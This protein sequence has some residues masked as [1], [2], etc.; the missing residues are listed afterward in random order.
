MNNEPTSAANAASPAEQQEWQRRAAEALAQPAGDTDAL[1]RAEGDLLAALLDDGQLTPGGLRSAHRLFAQ[2]RA[3]AVERAA[4]AVLRRS[5]A[6]RDRQ[7]SI[8]TH[9]LRTP[10][11]SILLN[12]QM[13]ERTARQRGALDAETVARMLAVPA[14]QLRR[15]THMVDLLLDSARVENERLVLHPQPVDLCELVHDCAGRLEHLAREAG[16]A[17]SLEACNPVVGHW[18]RLRLEQVVGNLLTNAI[19]YGG[20]RVEVA[21]RG[22]EEAALIVRDHGDGIAAPDQQ[23]IFEPFERLPSA[24]VEDGAGLGLYIVREIVRAHGGRIEVHSTPGQGA[25]FSVFL[26]LTPQ[27]Q[28]I[29]SEA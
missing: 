25:T 17:V 28:P 27:E 29:G 8:A 23:R 16:C 13:L 18:D 7:L 5:L 4:D 15:L 3:E 2:A 14:R 10:I 9:E 11:S 1:E 19:K 26:P 24:S 12:V 20:G 6:A 22:A 21:T